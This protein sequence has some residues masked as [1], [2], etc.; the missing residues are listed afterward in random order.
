MA[1]LAPVCWR[2]EVNVIA[3]AVYNRRSGE[4]NSQTQSPTSRPDAPTPSSGHAADNLTFIRQTMARS[5][6]FTAVPLVAG[7]AITYELWAVRAQ[8]TATSACT[9]ASSRTPGAARSRNTSITWPRLFAPR[10]KAKRELKNF[11][12]R[13][14]LLPGI[15][16]FLCED[17]ART[18]EAFK[19]RW[20]GHVPRQSPRVSVVR[21]LA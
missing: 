11:I 8:P 17:I 5:S 10:A 9:R 1:R 19:R 18:C 4:L 3:R 12:F 13:S 15:G 2:L 21:A 7:A 20:G 14:F 6:T 16:R